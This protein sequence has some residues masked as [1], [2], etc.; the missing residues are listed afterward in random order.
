[1]RF[2][3]ALTVSVALLIAIAGYAAQREERG[4]GGGKVVVRNETASSAVQAQQRRPGIHPLSYEGPG[5]VVQTKHGIFFNPGEKPIGLEMGYFLDWSKY[6]TL[7]PAGFNE[8]E[9]T[10]WLEITYD[11]ESKVL[12]VSLTDST[13]QTFQ[14]EYRHETAGNVDPTAFSD[15]TDE[16]FQF[17][18]TRLDVVGSVAAYLCQCSCSKNRNECTAT[19]QG[20]S[21]SCDQCDC[22]CNVARDGSVTCS[23]S[24][25][26]GGT[27]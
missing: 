2:K 17:M 25:R 8:V 13:G 23:C 27:M 12:N 26:Q 7:V 21:D 19:L 18:N 4:R 14:A 3:V 9:V 16:M 15:F 10:G 6:A 11:P 22:S 20:C 5:R 24:C 1:M